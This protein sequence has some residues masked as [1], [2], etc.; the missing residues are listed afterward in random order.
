MF[1]DYETL[2]Q[3]LKAEKTIY[4]NMI[5]FL[6]NYERGLTTI[7][8]KSIEQ[9]LK[10]LESVDLETSSDYTNKRMVQSAIFLNRILLDLIYLTRHSG[11]SQD[12]KKKWI[13]KLQTLLERTEKLIAQY[14]NYYHYLPKYFRYYYYWYDSERRRYTYLPYYSPNYY[15]EKYPSQYKELSDIDVIWRDITTKQPKEG[16]LFVPKSFGCDDGS[17]YSEYILLKLHEELESKPKRTLPLD[18]SDEDRLHQIA[19]QVIK[20][21]RRMYQR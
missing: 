21:G 19:D 20:D 5:N 11:L 18:N 7:D 17:Q 8:L 15:Y 9:L 2:M 4:E 6:E 12:V 3:Y 16:S 13:S 1:K 14:W 10:M